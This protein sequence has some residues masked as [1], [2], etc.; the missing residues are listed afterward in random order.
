MEGGNNETVPIWDTGG[1]YT[2]CAHTGCAYTVLG[3]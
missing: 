3:G 2:D 1:V